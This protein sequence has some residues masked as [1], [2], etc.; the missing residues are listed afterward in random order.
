M[1][2]RQTKPDLAVR[3]A[4]E[5]RLSFDHIG[6]GIVPERV[7]ARMVDQAYLAENLSV[8]TAD[9]AQAGQSAAP[10]PPK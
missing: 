7:I 9:A 8:Q 6:D 3:E 2:S 4:R 1:T 5:L 10:P